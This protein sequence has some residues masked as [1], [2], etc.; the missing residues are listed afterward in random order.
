[1]LIDKVHVKE[2]QKDILCN[3]FINKLTATLNTVCLIYDVIFLCDIYHYSK[4]Q[5]KLIFI[6]IKMYF[7]KTYKD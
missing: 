4:Q 6:N 3:D 5:Y 7:P 1:M 2:A